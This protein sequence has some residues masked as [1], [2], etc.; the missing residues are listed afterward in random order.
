LSLD[1]NSY[2][3]GT[4]WPSLI[5]DSFTFNSAPTTTTLSSGYKA[6]VFNGT[7]YAQDLTGFASLSTFT[8]DL[9]FNAGTTLTT[10]Y[11]LVG[12]FGQNSL[13]GW[14]DS[15]IVIQNN[16]VYVGF[17][18]NG[19]LQVNL[20]L[21]NVNS[22]NHV[23]FSYDGSTVLGYLNGVLTGSGAA[24]RTPPTTDYLGIG[25]Q[26]N[27]TSVNFV[28]Q[29][30]FFKIFNS[31]LTYPQIISNYNSLV[32]RYGL[33]LKSISP[34]PAMV[35]PGSVNYSYGAT[36]STQLS[37]N[38]FTSPTFSILYFG[39][40][41][42]LTYSWS[43]SA[44][45]TIGAKYIY[46]SSPN[47]SSTYVMAGYYY[48]AAATNQTITCTVT[49]S[50]SNVFTVTGT[51]Y[52]P[53]YTA[54]AQPYSL[55][56]ANMAPWNS[57]WTPSTILGFTSLSTARWIWNTSGAATNAASGVN[58]YFYNCINN[59]NNATTLTII[60]GVD[61]N[62]TI[63]VNN[64][65][66][67]AVSAAFTYTY[68]S[69][70]PG[71]SM[72]YVVAQ[73]SG[74]PAGF[75]AEAY[76]GTVSLSNLASYTGDGSWNTMTVATFSNSSSY[77]DYSG[78]VYTSVGTISTSTL[79]PSNLLL[80]RMDVSMSITDQGWGGTC[81]NIATN[82]Y[83]SGV[84]VVFGY[85]TGEGYNVPRSGPLNA[86]VTSLPFVQLQNNDY[87]GLQDGCCFPGGCAIYYTS[88]TT[89]IYYG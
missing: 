8:L 78:S 50:K 48:S 64:S 67:T 28:G 40:N 37:F 30:G 17:W 71:I 83:R 18:A 74:G 81:T 3:S 34:P 63:Y 16:I 53:G 14:N 21:Y 47:A 5:G 19:L 20:G 33:Q 1:A 59:T 52:W 60:G 56:A 25:T 43:I 76:F 85:N 15:M 54:F 89:T 23:S 86:T 46:V 55:G 31:V 6:I 41:T 69:L 27:P 66:G 73:N 58:I 65:A 82:I 4:S 51:I 70:P 79:N 87:I 29:I 7:P 77:N 12:E 22:W 32:P 42:P 49:D 10:Q 88:S 26:C 61:N 11:T 35:G 13:G 44:A 36:P 80:Y 84:G 24:T 45:S 68:T 72:I 2:S 75:Y 57:G 39:T 62:A 9:W 38:V